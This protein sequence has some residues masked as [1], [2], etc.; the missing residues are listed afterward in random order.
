M[1]SARLVQL[2]PD[3]LG[4]AGDRGNVLALTARLSA[5]GIETELVEHHRGDVLP[6]S[7]DVVLVGNGPLSA[8][9][10]ILDDLRSNAA[11]ISGW[12]DAGVPFFAYG[13][14]AELLGRRIELLDGSTIEGLGAFP[15][16]ATRV[17]K[18]TVGYVVVDSQWGR[19]VGFED[20]ASEW[21]L[22]SGAEPLGQVSLGDGNGDGG[23]GV[24]AG[25]SIATQVGGPVLPLN[26]ILTDVLVREVARR[27]GV[28]LPQRS[29]N[30]E[31]DE[32]ARRAREVIVDN[33]SHRFSRI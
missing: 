16:V 15:F 9:R 11:T 23:E 6:D 22:E 7:A 14:G 26:P 5:A 3:E 8:M 13:S 29:P 21:S 12:C 27:L 19:L 17:T 31:L 10:T 28:A 24:L 4:G 33:A 32:Y 18:R 20:N 2:Y 1:T 25:S 30:S